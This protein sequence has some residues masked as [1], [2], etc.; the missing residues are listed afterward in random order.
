MMDGV[1]RALF[2]VA[3]FLI[4]IVVG[5]SAGPPHSRERIIAL[6]MIFIGIVIGRLWPR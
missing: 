6:V 3:L 1:A 5:S 2:A 4:A